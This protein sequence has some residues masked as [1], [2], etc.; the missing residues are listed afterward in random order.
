M[1]LYFKYWA[2]GNKICYLIIT[3]H[4]HMF[5]TDKFKLV[6]EVFD[7]KF[8]MSDHPLLGNA[9][10]PQCFALLTLP[11]NRVMGAPVNLHCNNSTYQGYYLNY[12]QIQEQLLRAVSRRA[13]LNIHIKWFGATNLNLTFWHHTNHLLTKDIYTLESTC[14]HHLSFNFKL[15]S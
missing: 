12:S 11:C 13:C 3:E 8:K 2:I 5:K 15:D 7:Q 10:Y 1:I 6:K 14:W 9:P 4:P